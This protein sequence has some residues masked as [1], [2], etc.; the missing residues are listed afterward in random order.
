MHSYD[1]VAAM[2]QV[3]LER[4]INILSGWRL[5]TQTIQLRQCWYHA[6]E[7]L[8]SLR[9]LFWQVSMWC[10]HLASSS[11]ICKRPSLYW[12][13]CVDAKTLILLFLRP[14][15]VGR[16][17]SRRQAS[18]WWMAP[19][20]PCLLL[21]KCTGLKMLALPL[22]FLKFWWP[23][24]NSASLEEVNQQSCLYEFMLHRHMPVKFHPTLWKLSSPTCAA[25]LAEMGLSAWY[26]CPMQ[27]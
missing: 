6:L 8:T 23:H 5:L 12:H 14:S 16:G 25:T 10:F 4:D 9:Q 7:A 2:R 11:C 27:W 18:P 26:S 20:P 13:A 15:I 24:N 1:T 3:P 17:R 22:V 19:T 21:C